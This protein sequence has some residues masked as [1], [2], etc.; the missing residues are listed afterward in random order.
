M[1]PIRFEMVALDAPNDFLGHFIDAPSKERFFS[2]HAEC[3]AI[4]REA[5]VD[6]SLL[7]DA[8]RESQKSSGLAAL[9]LILVLI[10][11]GSKAGLVPLN[12]WLPLAHPAAPTHESGLRSGHLTRAPGAASRPPL[13]GRGAVPRAPRPA[14]V[15]GRAVQRVGSTS[16][17]QRSGYDRHGRRGRIAHGTHWLTLT[18]AG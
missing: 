12:A 16:A 9:V 8:I 2:N 11:T 10:G 5:D 6:R 3:S 15:R 13:S 7:F 17:L 1:G 14:S 4:D 18:A